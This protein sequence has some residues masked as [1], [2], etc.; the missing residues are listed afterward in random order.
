VHRD[1][2]SLPTSNTCCSYRCTG[3][4]ESIP[5]STFVLTSAQGLLNHFPLP[6]L[7]VP[8]G[9]QGLLNDFPLQH[10]SLQMHR[11]FESLPTLTLVLTD[12]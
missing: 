8:T 5:T 2:E 4:F 9:A 3:T 11:D 1:F 12:A 7:V 10:L 6:T